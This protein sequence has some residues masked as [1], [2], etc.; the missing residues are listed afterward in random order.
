MSIP[1][2]LTVTFT[3]SGDAS[4]FSFPE[5]A[6][7]MPILVTYEAGTWSAE[8]GYDDG[9]LDDVKWYGRGESRMAAVMSVLTQR[10]GGGPL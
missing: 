7:Q 5:V 4:P 1:E 6:V 2:E 3:L 8:S 10:V 9:N